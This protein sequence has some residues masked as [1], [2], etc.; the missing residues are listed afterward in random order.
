MCFFFALLI[1]MVGLY[2]NK[3]ICARYGGVVHEGYHACN[4]KYQSHSDYLP[5]GWRRINMYCKR[6]GREYVVM[7]KYDVE[8]YKKSQEKKD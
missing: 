8:E 1:V 5:N 6:C 4:H 3:H 7:Q 2:L